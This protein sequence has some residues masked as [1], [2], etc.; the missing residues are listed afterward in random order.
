MHII[1]HTCWAMNFCELTLAITPN[2]W[3]A[4]APRGGLLRRGLGVVSQSA[5]CAKEIILLVRFIY[6]QL[7][8]KT[9]SL[10]NKVCDIHLYTLSHCLCWSSLAHIWDASGFAPQ[11]RVWQREWVVRI[12]G[13]N[14]GHRG[15]L[16]LLLGCYGA[17]H[18]C[19]IKR[20]VAPDERILS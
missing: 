3:R 14:D 4:G 12:E 9:F 5:W 16:L 17:P 8:C 20:E 13:R 19:G 1:P 10:C 15:P 2:R 6:Y 18:K 11:I 7:F